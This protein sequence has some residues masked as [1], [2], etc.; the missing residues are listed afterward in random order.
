MADTTR[1]TLILVKTHLGFGSP[2][3]DSFKAHGSPLGAANVQK[4]KEK[5]GWPLEPAFHEPDEAMAHFREAVTSGAAAQADW[6]ARM[7]AFAGAFPE[8]AKELQGRQRE[9]LPAGWDADI[10]VFPADKKGV[11]TRVAGG[12][13][14]N[15]IAPKLPALVGGS[16]DLDPSTYTALK[17]QG[18]FNPPLSPGQDTEGSDAMGW[19]RSG[20]N[21]H[22]GVRE[23][24]MGSIV[25]GLVA[26]GGF[27][28]FGSTFLIFSDYM[29]PPIRL[30]ALMGLHVVARLHAR[31]PR[32]RRGRPDAPADRA[33]RQPARHSP[34]RDDPPRRR[35]RDGGGVEG[36]DRDARPA[37]AAGAD[38]AGG[39]DARPQHRRQRRG[40]ATG[41]LRAERRAER[42]GRR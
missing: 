14:M 18:D 34:A 19:S 9:E 20:R 33:A 31:Q 16:A 6:D 21:L 13:V 40:P 12:K 29:R 42:G 32:P 36:G 41:R 15:A 37:G 8:L 11:A 10:P 1:P 4:T 30:A 28:G 17:G 39:A 24:A 26:H 7:K 22:F 35:Q 2:E 27:I 23:H 38:A 25:N 3:Q 5:L